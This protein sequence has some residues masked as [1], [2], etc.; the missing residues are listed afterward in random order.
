[1]V[2]ML[3]LEIGCEDLPARF[4]RLALPQLEGRLAKALR[5]ARL[6]FSSIRA[7]GTHRRL[8]VIVEGLSERQE[9]LVEEVKGPPA[10]KAFDSEGRPTK[11]AEGFARRVGLSLDSLKVKEIGKGR[12]LVAEVRQKGRR[13]TEVLAEIIP[14]VVRG[15]DFPK[16]MRWPCPD[17]VR[18]GRP[19]RWLLCLFGDEVVPVRLAGLKAGR[20]TRPHRLLGGWLEVQ[21]A[22]DYERTL[23]ERGRVIVE[24]KRR[25]KTIREAVEEEAHRLGAKPVIPAELLDEVTYM[26]EWPS[27]A[28]GEFDPSFLELPREV[29]EE[30]LVRAQKCFPLSDGEG[31]LLPK[32]VWIR[33]GWGE[34]AEEIGKGVAKV[35]SARLSD[36]KFFFEEDLKRPLPDYVPE[37][38]RLVFHERLGSMLDKVR[39]LGRLVDFVCD[40]LGLPEEE[41]RVAL[42][43]AELCKADLVT[44][45]VQEFTELQGVMGREYALRSGEPQEV[46]QA[47]LDH[48]L[49]RFGGDVLP[50]TVPG[51]VVG[52]CDRA[53]TLVGCFALGF[54]PTATADPFGL[55]RAALSLCLVLIEK[56]IP[57]RLETLLRRAYALLAEEAKLERDEDETLT[58]L[59][60]F[61]KG[62]LE[63]ILKER[64]ID[65]DLVGAVLSAGWDPVLLATRR[66]EALQ[67]KREEER[68]EFE[69]A[70]IAFRRVANI[71]AQAGGERFDCDPSRLQKDAERALYEEA[72]R[73]A[74]RMPKEPTSARDFSKCLD[75]IL[76]LRPAIDRFFDEVL[77]MEKDPEIRRNR[78]GLLWKVRDLFFILGDLS[79][80]VLPGE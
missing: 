40:E 80:V 28:S 20:K 37:L 48:Y 22:E 30:V 35:I 36:A 15:L 74:S 50:K 58:E 63:T 4:A 51:A 62:R 76:S 11:A 79:K 49:P 41:R 18:F 13:A 42:R 47:I 72:E 5:E 75:L 16:F 6:P 57:L 54:R 53:D 12:Y 25:R 55:R 56:D 71:I 59:L 2:R 3:V 8:T 43:A 9:D 39:R 61:V 68:E 7:V 17:R 77:V 33:D 23:E 73:V 45:M 31:K 64:G 46:A 70:V 67:R 60:D 24:P 32:F 27:P 66:A 29:V 14:E 44:H 21:R 10:D 1:M 38:R 19:I 52:L 65:Y 78:L 69:A 34:G 26:C